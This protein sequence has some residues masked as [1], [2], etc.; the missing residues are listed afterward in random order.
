MFY[1]HQKDKNQEKGKTTT[2][3]KI[4]W[5][6]YQNIVMDNPS[7]TVLQIFIILFNRN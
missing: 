4:N 3:S 5:G 7:K 2:I 1:F 6:T